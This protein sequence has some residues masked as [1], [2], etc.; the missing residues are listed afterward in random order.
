MKKYRLPLISLVFFLVA[1]LLIAFTTAFHYFIPAQQVVLSHGIQ[2]GAV[3]KDFLFVQEVTMKQRYLSRIE[4]YIAKL[5][6][7]YN[8]SNVFLLI[9]DQQRILF[10]KRFSSTDFGEALHFPFNFGNTFDIGKG[11]KVYACIY[12]IDGDQQSYIGLARKENG[13]IG[14]LYVM[15]ILNNDV[16]QSFVNRQSLVDFKGTLGVRTYESNWRF[17]SVFQIFL[18]FIAFLIAM[19]I[20]KGN[21]IMPFILQVRIKPEYVF[22]VISLV[23]G[24]IMLIITPPFQVPDEPAHFYRSYQVSD[25]NLFKMKD[26]IPKS[27][28]KMVDTTSRMQ[29]STHEKTNCE[30]ILSL[31][32]IQTNPGER[33]HTVSPDYIIPYIPQ[34]LGIFMGKLL[35]FNLLWLFYLG[36][37]FNLLATLFLVFLAIRITPVFK[38]VFLLLGILPMSL[39]QFASLSYDAGT[40]CLSFLLL[41]F[42]LKLAFDKSSNVTNRALVW[43]FTISFMLAA[44]KPPYFLIIL[45]FLIIPAVRVGSIRKYIAVFTGLIIM[46]LVVSQLW[47]P[48]KKFMEKLATFP[49]R[50]GIQLAGFVSADLFSGQLTTN[51]KT[52]AMALPPPP[53]TRQNQPA[54]S[55][56]ETKPVGNPS[57]TN[58][59]TAADSTQT[60]TQPVASPFN[61]AEQKNF[62]IK[63]PITYIGII[64]N[65]IIKSG[66]LYLISIIGLFGW[67]DTQ[68]PEALAYIYL[69]I[70]LILSLLSPSPG[71]HFG[72]VKKL[73]L[74]GTLLLTFALIETAMYLYCNP[75]GSSSIIAVQGRYFIAISPLLFLL[76]Y[77]NSVSRL[78]VLTPNNSQSEMKRKKVVRKKSSEQNSERESLLEKIFPLASVLF[79]II[80]LMWSVCLILDRFYIL[81]M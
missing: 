10:T 40:I 67:I 8:N 62:I 37:L 52:L 74:F 36:R 53:Q 41:A 12:S 14:K 51:D 3:L 33:T 26:E 25:F 29:F 73:I 45:T 5:P 66:N 68:V 61:P 81:T 11:K 2:Y 17:F 65:T 13:N 35:G 1:S 4:I 39:Y 16:L 50:T 6:S 48:V 55:Q 79:A 43:L 30:E 15:P 9:D 56:P 27:L 19:M 63:N 77:N 38:W 23:F 72:I 42:I 18:Y 75:V 44:S 64:F 49:S 31:A 78:L 57:E 58:Q 46:C 71:I 69:T 47:V 7:Q 59:N 32:K 22:G 21:R 60:V 76:F 34:S 28:V 20:L 54:R 80:A 24:M 70:L